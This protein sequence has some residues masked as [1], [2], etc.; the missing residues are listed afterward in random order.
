[1]Q[2]L[3][4]VYFKFHVLDIMV[5]TLYALYVKILVHI[6]MSDIFNPFGLWML[7]MKLMD[8]NKKRC[9]YIHDHKGLHIN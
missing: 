6:L 3:L 9:R 4:P 1:M 5:S 7:T 8:L 2:L